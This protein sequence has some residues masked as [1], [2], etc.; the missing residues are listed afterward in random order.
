MS[1]VREYQSE[2]D[3]A[4]QTAREAGFSEAAPLDCATIKLL[5]EVRAMCAA[6]TCGMYGHNWACPPGCGDLEVCRERVSRYRWGILVQTVGDL[7]DSMDFEA[8]QETEARHKETF[9]KVS[10]AL[11]ADYPNLLALGA[12]CCTIC[13]KCA[14]PDAPCRFPERCISSMESY[15]ILVSDLCRANGMAY[16]YGQEK[17][18]YTSC[19][20]LA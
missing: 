17:I 15:G 13:R 2:L 6:N 3:K 19:Y 20:L 5:D 9:L 1:D 16:Y 8:M 11:K 12:G 18:A 14:Y 10:D 4:L 7:E